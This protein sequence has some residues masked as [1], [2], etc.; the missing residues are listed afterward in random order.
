[1]SPGHAW[2]GLLLCTLLAFSGTG[3]GKYGKPVRRSPEEHAQV[4]PEGYGFAARARKQ[5]SARAA[6]EPSARAAKEPTR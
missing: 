6:K 3:C 2:T 1:M 4:V 5:P